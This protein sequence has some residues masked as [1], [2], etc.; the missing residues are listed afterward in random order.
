MALTARKTLADCEIAHGLLKNEKKDS[1]AWRVHWVACLALLRAVG[2]VLRNIDGKSTDKHAK[3]IEAAWVEWKT[4]ENE[5]AIFWNFIQAERNNLLKQYAFGVEP[6]PTLIVADSGA[7]VVA[8]GGDKVVGDD[9]F[10]LSLEC[11][12]GQEGRDVVLEAIDWW[13]ARLDKIGAQL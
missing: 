6:E 13:K 1:P 8:E 9:Y 12:E 5:H 2:H 10:R 11:F 3:V 7:Q 4:N